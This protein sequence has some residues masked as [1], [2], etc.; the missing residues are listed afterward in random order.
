MSLEDFYFPFDH[1]QLEDWQ[2][3][4]IE[5]LWLSDIIPDYPIPDP[6]IY[7]YLGYY[8]FS[9]LKGN[10]NQCLEYFLR[11]IELGNKEAICCLGT[12]YCTK[13][14][15]YPL[16]VKC[17][18]ESISQGNRYAYK[19]MGE[20]YLEDEQNYLK[21]IE[22]FEQAQ[23][24]GLE[25]YYEIF[26][27]YHKLSQGSKAFK[28]LV[29]SEQQGNQQAI[30]DLSNHYYHKGNYE[31]SL[32]YCLKLPDHYDDR[33]YDIGMCYYHLK[34]Y[35]KM[36]GAFRAGIREGS[37]ACTTEL[38]VYYKYI[39]KCSLAERYLLESAKKRSC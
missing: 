6:I 11:S 10:D 39:E 24:A 21:A 29:L 12:Y 19:E 37:I 3:K 13:E 32:H 16:A 5:D 26:F 2:A 7:L 33:Y 30:I 38:G 34:D 8:H 35:P 1:P 22:C 15:C 20:Y 14:L 4:I 23:Q 17:Y 36:L 27:C 31:K 25:S 28:Y 9:N 18:L